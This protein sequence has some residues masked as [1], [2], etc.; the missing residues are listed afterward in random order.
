MVEWI[1]CFVRSECVE[2]FSASSHDVASRTNSK[3][4]VLDQ[5]RIRCRFCA[6]IPHRERAGRSS[7]FPSLTSRIYQSLTMMLRDHFT[8]C[9]AMPP[10]IQH[11]YDNLKA[12]VEQ[13][14]Q[15]GIGSNLL[16]ILVLVNCWKWHAPSCR[17][18]FL[19]GVR[20]G[21]VNYCLFEICLVLNTLNE[22]DHPGH[23]GN[24]AV[25]AIQCILLSFLPNFNCAL[26]CLSFG[27][28]THLSK[29]NNVVIL[30]LHRWWS[31]AYLG[32]AQR[33]RTI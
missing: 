27:R 5:A 18:W 20:R 21:G 14:I 17:S 3:K 28:R 33:R 9:R 12:N 22:H 8:I 32:I 15:R 25:F 31:V 26:Y 1:L 10:Q 13:M 11:K 23:F 2:V 19:W 4:V 6:H 29:K 7:S 30:F 16:M 24:T